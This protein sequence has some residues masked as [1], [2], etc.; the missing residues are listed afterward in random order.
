LNPVKY[1]L[2]STKMIS[3][4]PTRLHWIDDDGRD[5]PSDLCAHSPIELI[6]NGETIISPSDGDWAVNASTTILLRSLYKDHIS[7]KDEE[8]V[9][10]CCG[11]GMFLDDQNKLIIT[12]CP[13]GVDFDILHKK[14]EV[15]LKFS[16]NSFRIPFDDWKNAV[17]EFAIVVLNFYNYSSKKEIDDK[18]DKEAYEKMRAEWNE[19]LSRTKGG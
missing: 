3:I 9:F 19:L 6:V 1:A 16:D 7:G 11:H 4:K 15:E 13:E 12:G 5:D 2:C 17:L 14:E 8:H 10:P 18:Y